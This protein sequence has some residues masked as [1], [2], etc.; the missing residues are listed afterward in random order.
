MRQEVAALPQEHVIEQR[1]DLGDA[2]G[3]PLLYLREP[4]ARCGLRQESARL[5]IDERGG[6]VAEVEGFADF[7]APP[8]QGLGVRGLPGDARGPRE[9]RLERAL[10]P[11]GLRR[12]ASRLD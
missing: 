2:H 6:D 1:L 4:P 10:V 3:L 11:R 7:G 9:R 5:R 12:F 8:A